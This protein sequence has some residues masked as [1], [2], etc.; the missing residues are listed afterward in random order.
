MTARYT[1]RLAEELAAVR[2]ELARV[3]GKCSTLA[4]LAGAAA[5]FTASQSG[6]GPLAVRA[7][8]A[9]AGVAFT[10]AV[11]V[12]L[13]TVLRPRLGTAGWCRYAA[14][15]AEQAGHL[16]EHGRHGSPECAVQADDFGP[17][18]LLALARIADAKFRRLR[19]AV[20]LLAAGVVLLCAGM[21]A[22]ALGVS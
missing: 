9:A 15:T 5:A 10:A 16:A 6:H 18:D 13:L 17:A 7:I 12:L 22:A 4:G 1:W 21:L 3:D 11:L 19:L 2:G 20:D 8:L 14:M